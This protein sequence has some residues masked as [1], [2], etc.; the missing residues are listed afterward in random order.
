MMVTLI[1]LPAVSGEQHAILIGRCL[2]G[3]GVDCDLRL[4]DHTVSRRHAELFTDDHQALRLRDLESRNGTLVNHVE[5][6]G[7]CE[8]EDGDVVAFGMSSF[9]VHIDRSAA[10]T[11]NDHSAACSQ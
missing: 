3:R 8:L 5:L 9:E 10:A 11:P 1:P 7:E 2:I 6:T 4:P